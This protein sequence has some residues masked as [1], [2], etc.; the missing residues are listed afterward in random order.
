MCKRTLHNIHLQSLYCILLL[1]HIVWDRHTPRTMLWNLVTAC[2][3]EST[4]HETFGLLSE[5]GFLN[6]IC[7]EVYLHTQS[8]GGTQAVQRNSDMGSI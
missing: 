8:Y 4:S 7:Y 2:N 5:L 1:L 3:S 6:S